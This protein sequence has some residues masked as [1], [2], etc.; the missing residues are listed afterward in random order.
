MKWEDK[1]KRGKREGRKEG[2]E[3]FGEDEVG[4]TEGVN[5]EEMKGKKR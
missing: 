1:Q 4:R 3:K 2:R 5:G